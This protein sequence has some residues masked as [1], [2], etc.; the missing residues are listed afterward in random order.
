MVPCNILHEGEVFAVAGSIAS[1]TDSVRAYCMSQ[2][3]PY[4]GV[5]WDDSRLSM[6][7]VYSSAKATTS[8]Q[9]I[10]YDKGKKVTS[11]YKDS[12]A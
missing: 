1:D 4:V 9:C 11:S 12:K 7:R 10:I 6:M 3:E 2:F 8:V 5:G